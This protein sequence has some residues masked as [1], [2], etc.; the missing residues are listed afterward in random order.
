MGVEGKVDGC[1]V[2]WKKNKFS[3]VDQVCLAGDVDFEDHNADGDD[4]DH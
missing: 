2:F 3:L 1:A 4:D